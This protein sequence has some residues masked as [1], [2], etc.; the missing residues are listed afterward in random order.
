MFIIHSKERIIHPWVQNCRK[1]GE[2]C[3]PL[4]CQIFKLDGKWIEKREVSSAK[5]G[6]VLPCSPASATKYELSSR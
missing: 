2:G 1:K 3:I 5:W 6:H 4:T